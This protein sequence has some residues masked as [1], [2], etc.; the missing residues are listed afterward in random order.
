[1]YG[2]FLGEA[3]RTRLQTET[4]QREYYNEEVKSLLARPAVARDVVLQLMQAQPWAPQ[5]DPVEARVAKRG[6]PPTDQLSSAQRARFETLGRNHY[7]S[8][9]LCQTKVRVT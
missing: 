5:P 9:P 2:D 6:E 4:Q 7:I 3:C 1:M 8:H